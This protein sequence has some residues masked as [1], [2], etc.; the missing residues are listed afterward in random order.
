MKRFLLIAVGLIFLVLGAI[1]VVLP[2]LPTVPFLF[3]A[4]ICFVKSSERINTWFESTSIYKKHVVRFINQKGMTLKMKLSILIPVYVIYITLCI[5]KDILAMRIVIC[6]LLI[7][8]TI[9]FI[10]IK[11]VKEPN[12]TLK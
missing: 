9:V 2:I 6:T 4:S 3:V 10:K 8:K 7:I 5:L 1:G 12:K 11:T